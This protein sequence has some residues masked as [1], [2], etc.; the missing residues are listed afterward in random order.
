MNS[1]S[2]YY[3]LFVGADYDSISKYIHK[4]IHDHKPDSELVCDLGCGTANVTVRLAQ[5]GYDMIGID[6]DADMLV[7]AQQKAEESNIHDIL[8]LNQDITEFEL[9]GT[10]DVIYSTLD[11]INYLQRKSDVDK[12]FALV[13]NYLNYDGLFIFDINS[14]YK[15]KSVL[16]NYCYAY[17]TD[18]VSCIWQCSY[19]QKTDLC[20]HDLTYFEKHPDGYYI[21]SNCFQEQ[22]YYSIEFIRSLA[23][24][25]SFDILKI[26]DNYTERS[27]TDTTERIC[28]V[29]KINK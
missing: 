17:Q 12:L 22:R 7:N 25:Y 28:F 13:K 1:F 20:L 23:S 16:H 27:I 10:V 21:K 5:M 14:E 2:K 4:Q 15:F 9:Y 8:L 26:N 6:S 29:M 11:S 18:D 3:D 19:N 24:K